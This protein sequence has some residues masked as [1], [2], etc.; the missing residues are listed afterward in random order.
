[1]RDRVLVLGATGVAGN[2]AARR[3][4][5]DERYDV[6]TVS[7]RDPRLPETERHHHVA[8]DLRDSGAVAEALAEAG[9]VTHVVYAALYEQPD[10]VAGWQDAEQIAT[11]RAMLANVLAGLRAAGAPLRHVSLMQGT[12][13][14]A[15]HVGP[16][17][18]PAKESRPRVEHDNFYWAQEDL[19]REAAAEQGFG[20]TVWRPQFILG[21]VLGAAMNLVPVIACYAAVR[22][23]RGEPFSFPG[24]P[25]YVAE[26]VDARLLASAL[27][28]AA[29]APAAR[30]ETFNITNGDVFEW[31]DL[32]PALADALG[33]DPGPDEP[34]SLAAWLPEQEE[35]WQRVVQRHHLRAHT[36][37]QLV[38]YSHRFADDAFAWAPPGSELASRARPVLLSTVKLRQAGFVDCV[39]TEITFRHWFANLR[40]ERIIP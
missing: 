19:L 9:P 1:M 38:G 30:D 17:R 33:V 6:V 23:E 18:V 24:G 40:S 25:S 8:V 12:K 10:L 31:R 20:H 28:W 22:H 26:G 36:V 13:A 4:V 3:F 39:D 2:A 7:R 11:N 37:E 15:Y 35:V 16:M 27:H 29:E 14:Y 32:W 34:L 21:G 5:A